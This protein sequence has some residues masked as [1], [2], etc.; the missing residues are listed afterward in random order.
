MDSKQPQ[1]VTAAAAANGA[2]GEGKTVA[3]LINDFSGA[4]QQEPLAACCPEVCDVC[5][6]PINDDDYDDDD[7]DDDE[8]DHQECEECGAPI[9]DNDD[10]EEEEEERDDESDGDDEDASET[11]ADSDEDDDDD[12]IST[13]DV[14]HTLYFL[15]IPL[16]RYSRRHTITANTYEVADEC[17]DCSRANTE[18]NEED[19]EAHDSDGDNDEE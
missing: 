11:E 9:D 7:D 4:Q 1:Q 14:D 19:D 10:D 6:E 16:C 8:E 5:G 13:V 3:Q 17:I 12:G 18:D 15:G 2:Q